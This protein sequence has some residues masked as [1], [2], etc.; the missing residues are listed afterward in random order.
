MSKGRATPIDIH[1]KEGNMLKI[2]FQDG[3]GAHIIDALWDERDEQTSENRII[4]RKW[5]Y[6]MVSQMGWS[7]LK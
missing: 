5:A 6:N 3:T 7:V 4:F 2:E 1:D